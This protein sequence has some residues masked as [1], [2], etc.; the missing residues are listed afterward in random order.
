[1]TEFV[2]IAH[3]DD[4]SLAGHILYFYDGLS[5]SVYKQTEDLSTLLLTISN[6]VAGTG[7]TFSSFPVYQPGNQLLD[8]NAGIALIGPNNNVVDFVSYGQAITATSGPATGAT[9]T[10][11]GI[12]EAANTPPNNSIQLA[13]S[14]FRKEDFTWQGPLGASPGNI[15]GLQTISCPTTRDSEGILVSKQP[16]D[17]ETIVQKVSVT[18]VILDQEEGS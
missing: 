5:G 13:G 12:L 18:N 11:V 7:F 10:L 9:S 8:A 6:Q 2:E 16:I 3:S 14:G 1:M 4:Y 15:N 17:I